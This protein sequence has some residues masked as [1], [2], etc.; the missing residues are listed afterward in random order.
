MMSKRFK[1]LIIT[2]LSFTLLTQS[3]FAGLPPDLIGQSAFLMERTTGTVLYQKNA[4]IQ[5]YPASTTKILTS[6][7]SIENLDLTDSMIKTDA[8][9]RNVPS[10][11][12]HIGLRVGD[13]FPIADAIHAVMLG[14]D[15]YVSYDLATLLDGSIES[16]ASR[17]N[18][19][20]RKIGA[21]N[22]NFVNPHGY[23]DP[24]HY[25][26][27]HDLAVIM[28]YAYENDTFSKIIQT[29]EYSLSKL[30]DLDHPIEF[31]TTVK[32]IDP[33]SPYYRQHNIGGK[34]GF[35][36]AAGRSLVA[37]A[38]QD[39]ME[40]IGVVLKSEAK[41]FFEDMNALFD[42]GFDNFNLQIDGNEILLE[43]NS[44]SPWAKDIVSF[45]L[46]KELISEQPQSYESTISKKDFVELLMR[47]AYIAQNKG[48]EGFSQDH[49]IDKALEENLI[50]NTSLLSG[51]NEP[52]NRETVADLTSKFLSTLEYHPM[53]VYDSHFYE[54]L[55]LTYPDYVAS[56]Y[57][58]QQTGIMGSHKG[59]NFNPQG[60]LTLEEGLSIATNFYKLYSNSLSSYIN[61][62]KKTATY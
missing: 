10:D 23:H 50:Q 55:N 49:A 7:L 18:T 62:Y 4:N 12:S 31:S 47:T 16:F 24:N 13:V 11:S 53:K 6:I 42:Y 14:S 35:T 52:I 3:I 20:A 43:N 54:D 44:Y 17:M 30:N 38:S 41:E 22:S 27:A 8:S 46:E 1:H 40:L 25:T 58:L 5:M 32:L 60:N 2:L 39:G 15:N 29:P 28:D 59:G 61:K 34:T 48:L 45:A 26:T 21:Y 36:K 33:E 51:F 57:Y 56:I 37:V 19:K 9:V